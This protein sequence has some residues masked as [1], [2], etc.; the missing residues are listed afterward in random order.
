[1]RRLD[2]ER[3]AVI[4]GIRAKHGRI[5]Y[6]GATVNMKVRRHQAYNDRVAAFLADGAQHLTLETTKVKYSASRENYWIELL[7][8][9]RHPLLNVQ[10]GV[11]CTHQSRVL[12]DMD[13]EL[14]C[15]Q[16]APERRGD[17]CKGRWWLINLPYG[18]SATKRVRNEGRPCRPEATGKRAA[19]GQR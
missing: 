13:W 15:N 19:G 4:Y 11:G 2:P 14:F 17:G 9:C 8:M 16:E 7:R 1:M 3:D 10:H 18:G 6:V 5:V 12:P